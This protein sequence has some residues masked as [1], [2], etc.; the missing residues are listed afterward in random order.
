MTS[1]TKADD[2]TD[3]LLECYS[4]KGEGVQN[5]EKCADVIN[6]SPLT[7]LGI[8]RAGREEVKSSP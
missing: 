8:G 3:K 1:A 4:D 2:S 5:P 6:V 7:R